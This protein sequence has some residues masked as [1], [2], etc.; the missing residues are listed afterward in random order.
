MQTRVDAPQKSG[1]LMLSLGYYEVQ[2]HAGIAAWAKDHDWELD[3]GIVFRSNLPLPDERTHWSG[4][5]ATIDRPEVADWVRNLKCPVVRML[6][7][8]S[9]ALGEKVA[10]IPKVE[11]DCESIGAMGARHLLT[12]GNV[13][14]G[15]YC[16]TGGHD[17]RAIERGF[18]RAM[19]E[20]GKEPFTIDFRPEHP[21]LAIGTPSPRE[22]WMEWLAGKLASIPLPAAIMAEDDRFALVLAQTA[23]RMGIRIPT[24]LA[25]LGVDDN[26]LLLGSSPIGISSVDSDLWAVGYRAADLAA[27]LI[28][29]EPAPTAPVKIPAR[30]VIV[31]ESSTTFHGHHPKADAALRYIR[32]HFR[33]PLSVESVANHVGLS[34]RGLQKIMMKEACPSIHQ[35]ILRLRL[36]AA[37]QL[38]TET[39]LKLEAIAAE[40]GLGNA[41]NLC[42]V[43]LKHR[44]TTPRQARRSN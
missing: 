10:G 17:G 12:L 36:D 16:H 19:R 26:R 38:L 14:F 32:E 21:E 1:I 15:F 39:N 3:T 9:P 11:C 2:L 25:I 40:T 13:H 29:G 33:S 18:L 44:G 8:G 5:L 30:Q 31:R 34:A 28:S 6:E 43:F 4:V 41:K 7:A 23:R 35:E 27:R 24:E 20:A 22:A 42:R 37:E